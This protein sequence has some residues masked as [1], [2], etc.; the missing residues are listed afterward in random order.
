MNE[1]ER[2]SAI[3]GFDDDVLARVELAAHR[4]ETNTWWEYVRKFNIPEPR[5]YRPSHGKPIEV[6]DIQPWD[7]DQTIVY[8]QPMACPI[9]PNIALH[10]ATLSAAQP[11]CRIIAVGNPGPPGKGYGKLTLTQAADVWN[12]DF[13]PTVQPTLE[14][15]E[16]QKIN[17]AD[18][19]GESYGADK[20]AAA[21]EHSGLYELE[22][23]R[24]VMIEPVSVIKSGMVKLGFIFQST[25]KHADEYLEPVRDRSLTFT[26]A[27]QLRYRPN[28]YPVGIIGRLSNLAISHALGLKGYEG[29]VDRALTFNPNLKVGIAWGTASEFD[30]QLQR[31]QL[32]HRLMFKH[33]SERVTR[34][35]LKDETHAMNL[36]IFLNTAIYSQL[37]KETA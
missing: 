15:L 22:T 5:V 10:V 37:L 24:S 17:K 25:S 31:D 16:S 6:L 35:P 14:Y 33:G 21:A 36:D 34:M 1:F 18:H 13:Y 2:L 4:Q 30:R 26:S 28:L 8:H 9:D 11:E 20:A 23:V 32:T 19:I 3:Y 7:Y 12:G 29:R 27:E